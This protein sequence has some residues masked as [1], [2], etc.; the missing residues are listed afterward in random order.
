M[1]K[2]AK[3]RH[4]IFQQLALFFAFAILLGACGSKNAQKKI[5]HSLDDLKGEK[6]AVNLGG[7]HDNYLVKNYPEIDVFRVDSPQDIA[8]ALQSG[9]V[10]A[11]LIDGNVALAMVKENENFVIVGTSSLEEEYGIAFCDEALRDEFNLFLQKKKDNGELKTLINKWRNNFET[12]EMPTYNNSGENGTLKIGLAIGAPAALIRSNVFVGSEVELLSEFCAQK[13]M[14]P[15]FQAPSL[16]SLL[17]GIKTHKLDICG[18][19]ITITEERKKEMFFSDSYYSS[20]AVLVVNK[21]YTENADK[22][23]DAKRRVGVLLGSSCD[24]FLVKNY[25]DCEILRYEKSPE[26]VTSLLHN[27]SDVIAMDEIS[28]NEVQQKHPEIVC[29][30]DSVFLATLHMVTEKGNQV[31]CNEMNLFLKK[32]KASG[33]LEE[34]V[35]RWKAD[36]NTKMPYIENSGENGTITI[37]TAG[38]T[39]PYNFVRNGELVGIDIELATRFA[40]FI[41]KKPEFVQNNFMGVLSSV[42]SKKAD[43]AISFIMRTEERAQQMKFS[44]PYCTSNFGFYGLEKVEAKNGLWQKLKDSFYNNLVKEQR[45]KLVLN[46]MK[47]TLVIS[48]LSILLGTLLA[49]VV[50]FAKMSKRKVPRVIATVYIDILRGVPQVVLL[51]IMF[52]VVFASSKIDGVWVAAITFAMNFSAYVAEIF[53]TSIEGVDKG[54]T[55]AGVAM[56][57]TKYKTF[58][59][60]VAPQALKQAMPIFKGEIISLVKMTSIVGYIAVQDLTKAGDIIRSRTFDA[61]FPLIFIAVLYFLLAWMLT[62]LLSLA[63]KK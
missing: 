3:I 24:E 18:G 63:E 14:K 9:H 10:A 42:T 12:A 53:R 5:I 54:Q 6:V 57:F 58:R 48:I 4:H 1:R 43:M 22:V 2:I 11:T 32:M 52:Y 21:M 17:A 49:M 26:L 38:D 37:A 35:N 45:Y 61:F 23:S 59:L 15:E 47:V 8:P 27:S 41:G 20:K 56:G 34:I 46:G 29:V 36:P 60:I 13:K 40:A 16:T 33:A 19:N 50:C 44:E 31:L 25:S 7:T 51:M 30:E 39:P 28:L 62:A 55:E